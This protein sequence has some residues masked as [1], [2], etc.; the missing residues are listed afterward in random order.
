M[1]MEAFTAETPSFL[2]FRRAA[3]SAATATFSGT[4]SYADGPAIPSMVNTGFAGIVNVTDDLMVLVPQSY[5]NVVEFVPSTNTLTVQA[6]V[7]VATVRGAVVKGTDVYLIP[8]GH[9]R[10]QKYSTVTKT[11]TSLAITGAGT[12]YSGGSLLPDGRIVLCPATTTGHI[13][14]YDTATD[15]VGSG[16]NVPASCAYDGCAVLPNG[17]V[18]FAPLAGTSIMIWDPV[19]GTTRTKVAPETG[20]RDVRIT[21][22]GLALITT[23]STRSV[24]L[25]DY[26]TDELRYSTFL[27]SQAD[28]FGHGCYSANGKVYYPPDAMSAWYVYNVAL[29]SM[30]SLGIASP[31]ANAFA[32]AAQ[33]ADG[34]II[35]APRNRAFVGIL[36]PFTAPSSSI[37]FKVRANWRNNRM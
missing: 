27:P 7:A 13:A 4:P 34:R 37:D 36:T 26:R 3:D 2:D 33:A 35:C 6:A 17:E 29:G 8:L 9:N 5:P 24:L 21:P 16:P 23:G 12:L 15:T 19:A 22:D 20:Y 32:G 25:Y 30:A 10:M 1:R 18:I 28:K 14:T 11:V 31:S